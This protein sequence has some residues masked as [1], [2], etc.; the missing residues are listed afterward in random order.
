MR[1]KNYNKIV[2]IKEATYS[3]DELGDR[4]EKTPAE[5]ATEYASIK[6]ASGNRLIKYDQNIREAI[7]EIKMHY[8]QSWEPSKDQ[9]ITHRNVDYQVLSWLT[10]EREFELI[11]EVVK[12]EK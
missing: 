11:L 2:T 8:P 6:P 12:I 9:I 10:D 4:Y 1:H 3:T 7:F 5:I